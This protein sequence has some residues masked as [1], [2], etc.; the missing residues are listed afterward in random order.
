MI[1]VIS[2]RFLFM[3]LFVYYSIYDRFIASQIFMRAHTSRIPHL[4]RKAIAIHFLSFG[5]AGSRLVTLL[6]DFPLL[7]QIMISLPCRHPS[8]DPIYFDCFIAQVCLQEVVAFCVPSLMAFLTFLFP[9]SYISFIFRSGT[10]H[11]FLVGGKIHPAHMFQV[12]VPSYIN[13]FHTLQKA[14]GTLGNPFDHTRDE[15][16]LFLAYFLS[17]HYRDLINR[18]AHPG[19]SSITPIHLFFSRAK[20]QQFT[21]LVRFP[22]NLPALSEECLFWTNF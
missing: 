16:E 5:Q 19:S 14:F 2:L 13:Y 21:G 15:M 7:V 6:L 1:Q 4:R 20:M 3:C 12:R 22:E 10:G 8:Y 11:K 9:H 17:F 18:R